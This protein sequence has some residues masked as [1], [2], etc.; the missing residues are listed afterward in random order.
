ME[1]KKQDKYHAVMFCLFDA[2]I[3]SDDLEMQQDHFDYYATT[4]IVHWAV[5]EKTREND[6]TL[7]GLVGFMK[8]NMKDRL[9]DASSPVVFS[10]DVEADAEA[11]LAGI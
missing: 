4:P 11:L 1:D 8:T 2:E 3:T 10:N 5:S 6:D 7:K 9:V